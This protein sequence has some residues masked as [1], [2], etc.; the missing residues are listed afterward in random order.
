M[1]QGIGKIIKKKQTRETE[2]EREGMKDET[3]PEKE[4]DERNAKITKI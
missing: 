3:D 1:I 2:R 4:R